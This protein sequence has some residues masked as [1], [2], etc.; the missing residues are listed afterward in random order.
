MPRALAVLLLGLVLVGTAAA[1]TIRGTARADRIAAVDGRRQTIVCGRG[2]DVVN[3]DLVDRVAADCEVVARRIARDTTVIAGGAQHAT[4]LEPD[5]GALGNTIVAAFQ[6]GRIPGGG[7]GTIGWASSRDAGV[8]WRSGTLPGVGHA[9]DP[10][11]AFD[12]LHNTWLVVTLGITNGPTSLDVNR[13]TD[14][15]TWARAQPALSAAVQ[16][17]DKE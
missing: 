10:T 4:I 11:V 5:S 1:A 9:S 3:A 14:G 8:T 6:V 15:R 7:A 16:S 13:S 17:F 2:L 12:L